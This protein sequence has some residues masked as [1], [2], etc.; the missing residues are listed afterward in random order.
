[1]NPNLSSIP[2]LNSTA[3]SSR[4]PS[5][6][7]GAV[8][9]PPI[10]DSLT[11][12]VGLDIYQASQ[13]DIHNEVYGMHNTSAGAYLEDFER[14]P[15]RREDIMKRRKP[16]AAPKSESQR[17]AGVKEYH[18]SSTMSQDGTPRFEDNNLN[19]AQGRQPPHGGRPLLAT[20]QSQISS[21]RL[22]PAGML[23][24]L[25]EPSQNH[26]TGLLG[27]GLNS[28]IN[29]PSNGGG[30]K[31]PPSGGRS[32]RTTQQQDYNRGVYQGGR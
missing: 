29:N 8:A 9:K 14:P 12:K 2:N 31:R 28:I 24:K 5:N 22:I 27:K 20:H 11:E 4:S 16:P 26:F 19:R 32:R 7:T 17:H 21:R 30:N 1:M 25:G 6:N 15:L 23:V 18:Q 3:T 10:R 13:T